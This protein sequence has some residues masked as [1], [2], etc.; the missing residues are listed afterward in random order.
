M[1]DMVTTRIRIEYFHDGETGRWDYA[2]PELHIVGGGG[3]T[4]EEAAARAAEAIAFALRSEE[5]PSPDGV[6][7][8][9]LPIVVG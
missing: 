2:V 1:V 9:Y 5:S 3:A 6:E 7:V 4:K 8:G